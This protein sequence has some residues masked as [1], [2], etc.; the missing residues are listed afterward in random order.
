M[1]CALHCMA[2][3]LV[4]TVGALGGVAWLEDPWLEAIFIGLSFVIASWSL[5]RSY[6]SHHYWT[7]IRIVI[8][9]FI[10]LILSR[11]VAHA[12]EATLAAIGGITIAGAHW[13][14]WHLQKK[15][16]QCALKS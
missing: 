13:K 9:G 3:P 4:M 14:N 5:T 10:F 12:W 16:T 6:L 7:A 1:L 8:V 2:I 11:F 15:Y